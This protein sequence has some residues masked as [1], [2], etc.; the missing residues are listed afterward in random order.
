VSKQT[1]AQQAAQVAQERLAR[2]R[3]LQRRRRASWVS[4][5][6]VTV[7]LIAGLAGVGVWQATR[8]SDAVVPA[9]AT[10]PD[11]GV[12]VG[13]GPVTVEVYLDF[14][15]PIC[16]Q[17]DD[18]AR[19]AL[20][21]YVEDGT[22]TLVYHPISI[23]DRLSSTKFST[24]AASAAGCAADA[25]ALDEFVA[26][27]MANQPPEN[28]AGLSDDQIIQIGAGAGLSGAEFGQCVHDQAYRDWATRSTD[29][30]FDRGVQGTPTVFVAGTRLEQLSVE[31]LS[32]AIDAAA[33]GSS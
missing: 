28:S 27:M 29:A 11:G 8:P 5:V 3:R 9:A 19:P 31:D 23:L 7:L 15:C 12:P 16:K 24:R 4:A 1:R 33:Q 14:L 22:V 2:Q 6:A 13:T 18:A 26:A 17:F 21:R 20:D 32:A 25:G 30:A 10:A